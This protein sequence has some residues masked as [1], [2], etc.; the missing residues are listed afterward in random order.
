M[1]PIKKLKR[2]K[3]DME[4]QELEHE[5]FLQKNEDIQKKLRRKWDSNPRYAF[6]VNTLSRRAP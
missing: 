3:I 6:G 1:N 2:L 4:Y 5:E